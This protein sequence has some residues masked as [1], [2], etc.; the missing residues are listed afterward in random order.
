MTR[1]SPKVRKPLA[2]TRATP[3]SHRIA[4]HAIAAMSLLA[5][6]AVVLIFVFVAREALP[7]FWEHDGLDLAE[8][9][10][11]KQWRGYDEPVYVW[12]PI[13]GTAKYNVVPLFVGTLKITALTMTFSVPLALAAAVFVSQYLSPRARRVIKP[14]IELLAGI[15]S[16]V[17]GFFAL[18]VLASLTQRLFGFTYRLNGFVASLALSLTVIPV[19]FTIAEDALTS[20]PK[21]L[22]DAALALGARRHQ[23]IVRVVMP[24]ALPGIA[25]AVILG[26]GRAIGETMVVLMASGNASVM[27]LLDPSSSVR[28]VTATIAAELGEVARGET[29][30]RVLFLLG[31]M[32]F[33]VNFVLNRVGVWL[34]ARLHRHLTG[35]GAS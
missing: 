11:P 10:A 22:K 5:I 23:T 35:A 17:I 33:L 3:P 20:V 13:G 15:P 26:F 19:V 7:I 8:L 28:T 24:A 34:V 2:E 18:V 6:A 25:A 29:H 1:L 31:A 4:E 27:R 16:V 32:L 14:S 12:Q 30:W 21:P 9:F